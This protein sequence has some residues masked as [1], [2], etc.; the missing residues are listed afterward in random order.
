M[1]QP[2]EIK[3]RKYRRAR[4]L[5]Q[6]LSIGNWLLILAL[7]VPSS[8]IIDGGQSGWNKMYEVVEDNWVLL[9]SIAWLSFALVLYGYSHDDNGHHRPLFGLRSRLR[10]KT[11]SHP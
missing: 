2:H 6:F 10:S 11:H 1:T 3:T 9:V 5:G 8:S 7:L 4:R